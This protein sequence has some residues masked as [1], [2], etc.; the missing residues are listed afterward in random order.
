MLHPLSLLLL[1]T[2]MTTVTTAA[3][4]DVL[5]LERVIDLAEQQG[6]EAQSA[7]AQV[8][9]A[10]A[11][12]DRAA[13]A[14]MPSVSLSSSVSPGAQMTVPLVS[15]D[16][17][18]LCTAGNLA[19]SVGTVP[20]GS[21]RAGASVD[22]R[23]RVFDFGATAATVDQ[24]EHVVTATRARASSSSARVVAQAIKALVAVIADDE[25]VH[26]RERLAAERTQQAAVVKGRA[27]LGDSA[28]A[29]VLQAEVAADSAAFDVELARSQALV[30]RVTL[31]GI[32][33]LGAGNDSVGDGVG[34]GVGDV[35]VD[36]N[37][38]LDLQLAATTMAATAVGNDVHP[39]VRAA[40]E[41][42]QGATSSVVAAERGLWPTI[43]AS[44]SVGASLVAITKPDA[45]VT[46]SAGVGLS[47]S[48]P[49]LDLGRGADVRQ[50]RAS[51]IVADKARSARETAIATEAAR[52]SQQLTSQQALLQRATRLRDS[53]R[54][55]VE[56]VTAR[57]AGGAARLG[58]LLDAQA[59]LTSAEASLV[60]ARA[61]RA[62][63]TVDVAAATGVIDRASFQ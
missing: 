36:A 51:Q 26:V 33:G 39:D 47:L 28:M 8:A 9:V 30:D 42:L 23:W 34:D 29:D 31:L 7:R 63:A 32:L 55:A 19:C 48:W 50:A 62:Q 45:N 25:L 6:P 10:E 35:V 58:D 11:Q 41:D 49:L 13:T 57:V 40:R 17:S 14:T 54:V 61:A 46:P 52:A 1:A 27:E 22:A 3:R 5:T 37:P 24:R 44:A 18:A 53:A 12:R 15:Q 59:A 20:V 21:A 2:T 56:V 38:G 4:A 60:A 43:D 16:G